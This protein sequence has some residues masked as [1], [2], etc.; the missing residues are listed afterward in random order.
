ME[1]IPSQNESECHVVI[2]TKKLGP[3][4][5][6]K[7]CISLPLLGT[8]KGLWMWNP[9]YIVNSTDMLVGLAEMLTGWG[10]GR[11]YISK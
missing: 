3:E 2:M 4:E 11:G 7:K 1:R 5:E 6:Q 8:G 10:S 9:A